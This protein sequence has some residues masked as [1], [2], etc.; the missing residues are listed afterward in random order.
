M[1]YNEEFR[2]RTM[3]PYGLM[4]SSWPSGK[5]GI[6]DM[7]PNKYTQIQ[8]ILA[9]PKSSQVKSLALMNDN[10][11]I[12]SAGANDLAIKVWDLATGNLLKT[13]N[14]HTSDIRALAVLK[15]NRLVSGSKDTSVIIWK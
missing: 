6:W 15:D 3:T 9:H 2:N 7:S 12:A 10:K 5:I 14:G 11:S 8:T 4:D 1:G 13:L